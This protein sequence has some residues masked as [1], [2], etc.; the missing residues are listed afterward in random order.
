MKDILRVNLP[1]AECQ[2]A[3][4]SLSGRMVC[5]QMARGSEY[6]L[7]MADLQEG[8]YILRVRGNGISQT[9]KVIKK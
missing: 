1:E 2:L 8:V 5:Q 3:L 9:I 4:F 7:N 6:E